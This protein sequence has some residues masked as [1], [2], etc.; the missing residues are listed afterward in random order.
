MS[1]NS[2]GIVSTQTKRSI[3]VHGVP[4]SEHSSV[5]EL[6][7]CLEC[8]KPKRI[9]PTVSVSKSAEQVDLLLRKVKEKQG[10]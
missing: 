1:A 7:D 8:L 9:I 5:T 3:T 2:D 4:Y 10:H 6:V